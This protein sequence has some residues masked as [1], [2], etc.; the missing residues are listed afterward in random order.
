M[1]AT[2]EGPGQ[3]EPGMTEMGERKGQRAEPRSL[4]ILAGRGGSE[5]P[6]KETETKGQ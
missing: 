5:E 2:Y 4:P 3:G 6:A 1:E